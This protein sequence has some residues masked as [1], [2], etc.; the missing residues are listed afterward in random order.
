MRKRREVLA[1]IREAH[2]SPLDGG[3]WRPFPLESTPE[4]EEHAL[5]LGRALVDSAQE[6]QRADEAQVHLDGALTDAAREKERA[7]AAATERSALKTRV[8]RA[9]AGRAAGTVHATA[10]RR[11]D[12]EQ[13]RKMIE[14]RIRAGQTNKEIAADLH[15]SR[16]TVAKIRMAMT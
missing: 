2:R 14:A 11:R 3:P 6:A 7:D 8:E 9:R 12:A 16:N 4:R 15:A 1:A 5:Q 10:K 13:K